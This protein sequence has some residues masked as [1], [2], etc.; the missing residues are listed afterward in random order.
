M[1]KK[2]A[3]ERKM[4]VKFLFAL[5]AAICFV[6]SYA[7][8]DEYGNT[9]PTENPLVYNGQEQ[10][11]V[12]GAKVVEPGEFQYSKEEEGTYSS[13]IPTAITPGKYDVWYKFIPKDEEK[14]A[15]KP[16]KITASIGQK[17]LLCVWSDTSDVVYDGEYHRPTVTLNGIEGEDK[18]EASVEEFRDAGTYAITA[19]LSG[20]DAE[21]YKLDNS[22][23]CNASIYYHISKA[24]PVAGKDFIAPT[25][26]SLSQ[27]IYDGT[28]HKLV[29]EGEIKKVDGT[30]VYGLSTDDLGA[31]I[32]TGK[33]PGDYTVKYMFISGS[34]NH[35]NSKIGSIPV[36]IDLGTIRLEWTNN[37]PYT[38][39]GQ[40]Q[41]PTAD[42]N[43]D[44]STIVEDDDV[45]IVV[46]GQEK[47]V[48]KNYF[49]KAS[50]TG[51]D[52]DKYTLGTNKKLGFEIV[53][54]PLTVT[55]GDTE[56]TYDGETHKP[57]ASLDGV[58][59]GE[60]LSFA[61]GE[62]LE[63]RSEAFYQL[64]MHGFLA[65]N[66]ATFGSI[67]AQAVLERVKGKLL[68]ALHGL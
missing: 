12:S 15:T 17:Q 46:T 66:A 54:K 21:R 14:P 38:Y 8:V 42:V 3:S 43:K 34:K 48:G 41:G 44:L 10:Q 19:V 11:L 13:I 25:A 23:Y 60:D 40:L 30:F 4:I 31:E 2:F 39:N 52:A 61:F 45:N 47:I 35:E 55:W 56:F 27:L 59:E 57:T 50:L 24:V 62:S 37:T 29:N 58:V 1:C 26:T 16:T 53:P 5:V 32:P 33:N 7:A 6:P 18:V 67:A 20:D 65:G 9:I 36:T 51:A 64:V 49:V 28:D 22:E 63:E 68:L